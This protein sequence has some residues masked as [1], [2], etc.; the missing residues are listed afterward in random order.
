MS[1]N[2]WYSELVREITI[3][4]GENNMQ[5]DHEYVSMVIYK[6][7]QQ[8]LI[9]EAQNQRLVDQSVDAQREA[10]AQEKADKNIKR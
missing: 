7:R 2:S 10:R 8:E 9:R 1:L 6:Q 5:L 3:S 4:T